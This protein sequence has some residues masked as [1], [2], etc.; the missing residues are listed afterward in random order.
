MLRV[1][2]IIDSKKLTEPARE[3]QM[4]KKGNNKN[5]LQQDLIM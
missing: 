2:F 4:K 5:I 3:T 1:E